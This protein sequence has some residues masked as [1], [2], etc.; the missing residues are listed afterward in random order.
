MKHFLGYSLIY[1]KRLWSRN[2]QRT[3]LHTI[4]HLEIIQCMAML[5]STSPTLSSCPTDSKSMT[6]PP[7][8]PVA[9]GRTAPTRSWAGGP[10]S[11]TVST[12]MRAGT[13]V[14]AATESQAR[15]LS[16]RPVLLPR[17]MPLA[18]C[19]QLW[20]PQP[21]ACQAAPWGHGTPRRSSPSCPSSWLLEEQSARRE[22][23]PRGAEG[24]AGAGPGMKPS[25]RSALASWSVRFPDFSVAG[26][27]T[28]PSI[29]CHMLGQMGCLCP[30]LWKS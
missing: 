5:P 6:L 22:H 10:N 9:V 13:V 18:R 1:Y 2:H 23:S 16:P 24:G 25:A 29:P 8:C 20:P 12:P 27:L 15:T 11:G 3:S 26:F 4:N 21:C 28:S 14:A 30:P 17:L 7:A 19:P